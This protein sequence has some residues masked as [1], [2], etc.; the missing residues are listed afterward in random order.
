[1]K[2]LITALCAF[3]L[4]SWQ[5]F[6]FSQFI[7]KNTTGDNLMTIDNS[8]NATIFSKTTTQ[9]LAIGG[10]SPAV[11]KVPYSIDS[12]GNL[13]WSHQ[14]S[15]T[16]Q[17]LSW[18]S[19]NDEW[20]ISDPPTGI[21]GP[22]GP[23]GQ[24][25]SGGVAERVAFWTG[26]SSL[27][28]DQLLR[29]NISAQRLGVGT[30]LPATRLHVDGTV[31]LDNL[32]AGSGNT[33]VVTLDASN[34][35]ETRTLSDWSDNQG[36]SVGAGTQTTS[37]I[38]ISGSS[39]DITL[40]EGS[41]IALSE[42][43]NTITISATTGG[44]STYWQRNS[45]DLAPLNISDQVGIGTASPAT[46]L[47]VDGS[48]RLE[49]LGG[50][51]SGNTQV[52]TL[53]GSGNVEVR[54]LS[55]WSDNQSL[56]VGAGS[57]STSIINIS[58]S[59]SNVTLAE[60]SNITLN[61]S[62]NTITISASGGTNYWQR[63]SGALAPATLSDDVGIGTTAPDARLQAMDL[64]NIIEVQGMTGDL[65]NHSFG[66]FSENTVNSTESNGKFAI[67]GFTDSPNTTDAGYFNAGVAG[68]AY[69]SEGTSIMVQGALGKSQT[70]SE[71][72]WASGVSGNINA[73]NTTE[74]ISQG[75]IGAAVH[76]RVIN[77][78]DFAN[79][80]AGYFYGAKSYFS[81]TVT[82]PGADY[83]EWF[84]KEE[85]TAAG[86][87]IG[88]NLDTGRARQYQPGDEYVGVHSENP[89]IAGN[90]IDHEMSDDHVLVSL[91]GQVNVDPAQ[92]KILDGIVYTLDDKKIGIELS[93][94]KVL[95]KSGS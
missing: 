84:E 11:G 55:D 42:S 62:G 40:Q 24:G 52:L 18:N 94:G 61:E 29:W 39:S 54:S 68:R 78:S 67:M 15:E 79:I 69:D 57:G 22:P 30:G 8:G 6:A 76:A 56:S 34:N 63:N 33:T 41:N 58:N 91:L 37:I 75:G 27:G 32:P 60:G 89:G 23:P 64:G 2:R 3:L 4:L 90:S 21:P 19:D 70:V 17:I 7:V 66:I 50:D 14:P 20:E 85:T 65:V 44:G 38:D 80:W 9:R 31:R 16:G 73:E 87:V 5:G 35:V 12:N 43:G 25:L 53:D 81:H 26:E 74:Y 88:I 49:N 82:M 13:R 95:L 72:V 45:G 48:V 28:H 10:D 83:A 1:M 93:S 71:G 86:D 59:S 92:I 51:G 47:H 77:N 46:R 36:L